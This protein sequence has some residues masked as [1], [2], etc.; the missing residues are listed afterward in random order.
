METST[1]K[2][3]IFA[4]VIIGI[5]ILLRFY[6]PH[7]FSFETLKNNRQTF[8]TYVGQHYFIAALI[9]IATYFVTTAFAVPVAAPLTL[10][11]GFLFGTVIGGILTIVGATAGALILFLMV[12]FLIGSSIQRRYSDRLAWLNNQIGQ[13]GDSY[14][15]SL[16]FLAIVPFFMINLVAGLTTV[17]LWTYGWTTAIG[18]APGSLV[19]AFAGQQLGSISSARD[20]FTPHIM[21]AFALLA[22]LA[23]IPTIIKKIS[24]NKNNQLNT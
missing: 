22:L 21:I 14:L 12:R 24:G 17:S 20:V 19:F 2:K 4:C 16:R 18:I 13:H 8:Q 6:A 10:I 5:V 11:G 1:R 7:Y 3:I 23:L 9:Y 15:L